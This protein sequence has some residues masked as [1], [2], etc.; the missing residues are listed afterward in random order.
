MQRTIA[1]LGMLLWAGFAAAQDRPAADPHAC[2]PMGRSHEDQRGRRA[3]DAT[4]G[5]APG[6]ERRPG[7]ELSDKL[8]RSEGVICPPD[9]DPK[10]RAPT[11]EGG[12]TP[13]IPPPGGP[14]GDPNL[15][16]K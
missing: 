13:V 6:T 15:R 12:R 16:P 14:G 5:Q 9:V 7:E 10:I 4:T 11:P 8:A 1:L 2:A 3:P